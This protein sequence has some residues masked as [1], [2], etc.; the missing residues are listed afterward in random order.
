MKGAVTDVTVYRRLSPVLITCPTAKTLEAGAFDAAPG[1]TTV[2]VL[3]P[4][5]PQAATESNTANGR[6]LVILTWP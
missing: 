2:P 5:P 6:A 4:D 3:E 1:V